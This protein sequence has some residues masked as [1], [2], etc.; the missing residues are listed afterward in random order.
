MSLP[1]QTNPAAH[2]HLV[3]LSPTLAFLRREAVVEG[4]VWREVGKALAVPSERSASSPC[5]SGPLP[6]THVSGL[7]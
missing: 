5:G 1:A 7:V 6:C 2:R 3:T 4:R